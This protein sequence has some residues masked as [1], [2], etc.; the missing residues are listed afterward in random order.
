M[1]TCEAGT[2]C[3][4]LRQV[5]Q[6]CSRGLAAPP[7]VCAGNYCH[8]S[9]LDPPYSSRAVAAYYESWGIEEVKRHRV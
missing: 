1:Y 5:P 2:L 3:L 7:P 8:N 4:L 9:L 6:L